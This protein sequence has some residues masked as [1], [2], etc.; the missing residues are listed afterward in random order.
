[1][2]GTL[3]EPLAVDCRMKS[4]YGDTRLIEKGSYVDFAIDLRIRE[5]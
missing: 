3:E 2:V 4:D 5:G 1:M